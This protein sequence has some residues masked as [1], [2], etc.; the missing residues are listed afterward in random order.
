MLTTHQLD[1]AQELCDRI[2]IMRN[3]KL[4]ADRPTG[5]LLSL[6]GNS[7]DYEITLAG[8]M[9]KSPD[10]FP[11]LAQSF[12]DQNTTLRGQFSSQDE[13]L[14]T[15]AQINRLGMDV[16]SVSRSIPDLEDVFIRLNNP[17]REVA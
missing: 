12:E 11:H 16:V 10:P 14:A 6:F 1:I 17:E 2:A 9:N 4:V 7:R 15:L 5:E 13:A 8:R 3:G